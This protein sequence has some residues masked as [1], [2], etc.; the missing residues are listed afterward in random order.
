MARAPLPVLCVAFAAALLVLA[1]PATH[2]AEAAEGGGPKQLDVVAREGDCP[3]G[4]TFC[5]QITRAP[6][7]ITAGDNVTLEFSNRGN[8]DHNLHVT[9]NG[10]A[11]PAHED[12]PADAA[13]ARTPS[14]PPGENATIGFRVPETD[15]LY[16]WGDRPGHEAADEWETVPV[17]DP[18]AR[19]RQGYGN[20]SSGDGQGYGNGSGQG[21]G[22][23]DEGAEGDG[24]RSGPPAPL[25]PREPGSG[26]DA[27][28][29]P[30]WLPGPAAAAGL[31]AAAL[32]RRG[33]R[34]GPP[35]DGTEPGTGSQAARSR[36]R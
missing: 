24:N 28:V 13:I 27:P 20:G 10:S 5:I 22:S 11:D 36:D 32:A 15:A 35:S 19:D 21:Y 33:R 12:T 16:L 7:T 6:D 25:A 31:V 3:E 4:E 29:G 1:A 17:D 9:D 23:G 2:D 18:A 26:R 34:G 30:G 8:T 14:I